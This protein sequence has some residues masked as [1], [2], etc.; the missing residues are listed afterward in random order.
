MIKSDPVLCDTVFIMLTS[1]GHWRELKRFEGDSIDAC[2]IKPVRQSQL[3]DTLAS[4]WSKKPQRATQTASHSNSRGSMAA[5]ESALQPNASTQGFR[6]LVVEDNIVNQ[7]VATRILE[8]L[9]ARTDVAA[10]G[11]EALEMLAI[12][13]YDVVLLDCQMPEMDGYEAAREIRRRMG[14]NQRVAII[15]L[16]A[17]AMA[18]CRERCLEAGM[19][20]FVTKPVRLADLVKSLQKWVGK[21]EALMGLSDVPRG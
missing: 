12:L 6:A 3:M 7:K 13:P 17:E 1:L 2:L 16:T 11:R 21:T 8:R 14:P 15:A 4:A 10:N 19:D 9:G 20:D 5:L 18:G